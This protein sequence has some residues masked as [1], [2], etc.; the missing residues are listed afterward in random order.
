M[1]CGKHSFINI[2]F[3]EAS[4]SFFFSRRTLYQ[5]VY[6]YDLPLFNPAPCRFEFINPV[7][8]N[9]LNPWKESFRHLYRG[10]HVRPGYQDKVFRGRNISYFNTVQGALDYTEERGSNTSPGDDEAQGA[11]IFLHAGTYRGEFLVI[12]SDVS[13]IGSYSFK[14]CIQ[15]QLFRSKRALLSEN[16]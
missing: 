1:N 4:I 2:R 10:V 12:D 6:E 3:G 11:L 13:L 9:H 15:K 16:S 8:S 7:D 14:K 5:S